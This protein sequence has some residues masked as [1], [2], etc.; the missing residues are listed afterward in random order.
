MKLPYDTAQEL[1]SKKLVRTCETYRHLI[2]APYEIDTMEGIAYTFEETLAN[3]HSKQPDDL[4]ELMAVQARMLDGLFHD[5]LYDALHGPPDRRTP[6]IETAIRMQNQMVKT[7][8]AWKKLKT[9]T[10]IVRKLVNIYPSEK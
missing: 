2:D 4:C 5:H 10:Y 3:A 8:N 1:A 9:S 6:K 7:M